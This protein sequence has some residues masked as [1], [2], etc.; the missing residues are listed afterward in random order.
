MIPRAKS[1][2]GSAQPAA[3]HPEEVCGG[4]TCPGKQE[5]PPK[6]SES[7]PEVNPKGS[8]AHGHAHPTD[9]HTHPTRSS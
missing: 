2:Q 3:W 7:R 8:H 6:V 5:K 1:H 9:K 4:R